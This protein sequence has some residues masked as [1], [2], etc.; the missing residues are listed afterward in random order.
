MNESV[1]ENA[2]G[3]RLKVELPQVKKEDAKI[4]MENHIIY[5]QTS[6]ES[7]AELSLKVVAVRRLPRSVSLSSISR[8][9]PPDNTLRPDHPT[10]AAEQRRRDL[11]AQIGPWH[12]GGINE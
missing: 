5:V 2:R 12:H 8:L 4:T 1:S 3:Y 10:G 7:F 9:G 6:L 11:L